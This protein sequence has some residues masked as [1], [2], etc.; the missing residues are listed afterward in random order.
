[1]NK[2]LPCR[3]LAIGQ[4]EAIE[5]HKVIAKLEAQAKSGSSMDANK[6]AAKHGCQVGSDRPTIDAKIVEELEQQL[7]SQR[8]E[9]SKQ[10]D[11]QQMRH[12]DPSPALDI[13]SHPQLNRKC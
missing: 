3:E 10:W 2:N 7:A 12:E 11:L 9:M 4:N 1:M 13:G 6:T 5:C 8:R